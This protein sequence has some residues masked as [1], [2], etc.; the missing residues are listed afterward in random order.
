MATSPGDVR[1]FADRFCENS[2]PHAPGLASAVMRR[3]V[4][5]WL[6]G[7]GA[8]L[9]LAS[10]ARSE[11]SPTAEARAVKNDVGNLPRTALLADP[12]YKEHLTGSGHPESPQ[13]CDAIAKAIE[14]AGLM[15]GLMKLKPRDADEKHI[16]L[17]HTPEYLKTVKRDVGE[18]LGQL[19]TGDT[20]ISKRSLAVAAKAVGG[21]LGAVDA[22][23]KRKAKNAFCIIRPPGHHATPNRGMGF[24]IFN[25]AAIAARYAQ[26]VHKLKRALIVDWDVHH[27]NGTQDIFYADASVFY[28][29]THQ[30]PFYPG[31]GRPDETGEGK[32]TGTTLNCPVPAGAGR[33]E[34]LGAFKDKLVPAADKFK[35]D[36]V[37]ISAGF[38]SRIGDPIGGFRLTDED[39]ADLTKV[40][41]DIAARHAKGRVVSVLEGGYN[42]AGLASAATAHVKALGQA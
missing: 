23:V 16:L 21:V 24:C 14:K 22:V 25:N 1:R 2:F 18:G 8:S 9:F 37:L 3:D 42:L 4:L 6:G 10:C 29:S 35:P 33:K 41:L 20:A 7:V 15:P 36:I 17:C 30:W 40:M 26:T 31:T 27:G 19:T 11:D 12:V 13:R 28:F 34:I 38:D 39:F 32:G 5:K